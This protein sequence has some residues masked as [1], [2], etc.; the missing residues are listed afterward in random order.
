M[1]K[2]ILILF[3]GFYIFF[4]SNVTAQVPFNADSVN[5]YERGKIRIK[6]KR[7]NLQELSTISLKSSIVNTGIQRLDDL[8]KK[9]G[10]KRMVRVFPFSIKF[11][12]KHRKYGLH[13]WYELD[14]DENLDPRDMADEYSL[15]DEVAIA[16]PLYKKIFLDGTSDSTIVVTIDT[17]RTKGSKVTFKSLKSAVGANLE[18]VEFNDP[19]LPGQ[20]HYHN[21]GTVGK[22]GVDIDLFKA[23][24]KETGDSS[25]IVSVVDGGIDLD[26][27]DIKD[28]LWTN[29]AELNGEEGVDDDG[30]G[31]VDDIHGYNFVYNGAITDHR[32][33]T[34]VAGTVG[35]V[36][37]NGVGVCGVAG[38]DGSGNAVRL[39]SCQVYD[40][41]GGSGNF[42][43]AIVYGADM[44]AVVSQNSWGYTQPGFYE[45]EVYD[46]CKYFIA[47]A[48][49]YE[50]SPMKGGIMFFAAGN[51]GKEETHYPGS[52]P[53]VV[54]VASTGPEGYP[55]PYSTHGDWVDISAPG[56]DQ[57]Y[58]QE[59]GGVLSTLP[60][61]QYGYMQGT[62]MAC[63]HVSGVAALAIAK[64][65]G[66]DLR[67]DN[68]KKIILNSTT[69][70]IFDSQGKYGSGNINAVLA[71]E[72][73][74]FISPDPITD[75][76]ATEVFHNEARL[77]W[78]VPKDSD[79]F[80]PSV[81]IVAVSDEPITAGNFNDRKLYY[82]YNYFDA[83][84]KLS[85]KVGGLLKKSNYWFAVK[86]ADRHGNIS[87]ISNILKVTTTDAPHFQAPDRNFEF[88][89]DVTQNPVQKANLTF[90][91]VGQGNVYWSSFTI[92][93]NPWW[94]PAEEWQETLKSMQADTPPE[95]PLKAESAVIHELKAEQVDQTPEYW[96][97]DKTVFV[98]GYTYVSRPV[99]SAIGSGNTNVGLIHAT[100]FRATKGDFNLTHL[101]L[102]MFNFVKDPVYIEIKRGSEKLEDAKTE[103]VQ[104][105]YP[106]TTM[107]LN[108]ARIPIFKPVHIEKEEYFWVVLYF[109][110]KEPYPLLIHK[111]AWFPRTFYVSKDNG[112]T[113][114]EQWKYYGNVIPY[115][116]AFSTGNDMSYT[117]IS[118][119]EGELHEAQT[120]NVELT[121]DAQRI[122]NGHHLASVGVYTSDVDV[123]GVAIEVKVTVKGQVAKAEVD[124]VYGYDV[125]VSKD[126]KLDIKVKNVGLD[127]LRIYDVIDKESG[128]SVKDFQ[129]SILVN[130][131][132]TQLIPFIFNPDAAGLINRDY[133]L[134]T[135]IGNVNIATEMRS[136]VAPVIMLK[137]DKDNVSVPVDQSS[138]VNLTIAN[139]G[140][141]GTILKYDISKYK[142]AP[143]KNG[144]L[145]EKLDYT[146]KTSHDAVDPVPFNWIDISAYGDD[147]E[148]KYY[149]KRYNLEN[150]FPLYSLM[151]NSM[152]VYNNGLMFNIGYGKL[153]F[154]EDVD[155]G[156]RA[157]GAILPL[158]FERMYLKMSDYY[159]YSF[160]DK[161][162]FSYKM[163]IKQYNETNHLVD[164]GHVTYQ[165]VLYRN[166]TVEY[167]YLDMEA[168]DKLNN[169]VYCVGI[170]G[171]SLGDSKFYRTF[172]DT[173]NNKVYS[174]LTIRFEPDKDVP[175][176]LN[177]GVSSGTIRAK[178]S[179]VVPVTIDPQLYR[180]NI[181]AGNYINY[182]TV[183]SNSD[184]KADTIPLY[185]EVT[186]MTSLI[187]E[188]TVDF[189]E[190]HV[191]FEKVNYLK[192]E[193]TGAKPVTVTSVSF[194]N[195]DFSLPSALPVVNGYAIVQIPI[196]Y[197]P[198]AEGDDNTEA[199]VVFDNGYSKI[200]KILAK[201]LPD[202]GYTINI[203]Q[204]IEK[205][206]HGGE[207]V[208][209]PFTVTNIK[210]GVDLNYKFKNSVFTTVETE[211]IHS[212]EGTKPD[213]L[214]EYGYRWMFSDTTR[215][216]Y[217]WKDLKLDENSVP[218][219]IKPDNQLPVKLPFSFPFYG[220]MYD[221][222]WV[223]VNGYVTVVKPE[224]DKFELEFIKGDG[225]KGMIAPFYSQ[226]IPD[227][228]NSRVWILEESD[229]VYILWDGYRGG[230]VGGS[231]GG[232]YFQLEMVNDGSIYFHYLD[233]KK[234][235]YM[236]NYGLESPDES[237]ILE[238]E[239]SWI[240]SWCRIDDSTTVAISPPLLDKLTTTQPKDFD[241]KLSA[242]CIYVPGTYRDTVI[243]ETNSK[244]QPEYEIPVT[245]N[246]TGTPV[247]V[248]ADSISWDQIIFAGDNTSMRH[249][250]ILTNTGHDVAEVGKITD[251]GLNDFI[252]Y[253]K[254]GDEIK[255]TSTGTLF[256]PIKI[257]PWEKIHL[258][259]EVLIDVNADVDGEVIFGG[260]FE[261][262]TMKVVAKVVDSPVF[263]W[264]AT[265]QS[266]EL[267]NTDKPVY[268]F[269]LENN[270]ETTLEYQLIPAVIPVGEGGEP[271][272]SIVDEL[273]NYDFNQ[274][275]TVDSLAV[276]TKEKAD[277]FEE[278]MISPISLA[279]ANE[280][281][282]PAGGF[283]LT[284]VKVCG[285]FK[286]VGEYI[287]IQV[288]K[289]GDKPQAGK[290]V[291]Q[292]DY[293]ID[294]Y[295]SETWI[296]F[297]LKN[298]VSFE[299]GEHFYLVI[300]PPTADKYI[301]Y[302]IAPNED[303]V[304][305]SWAANWQ[306]WKD[307]WNWQQY[308]NLLRQYKIR[309]LT[310][311][312][313]GL[314]LELD[315]LKG[316]LKGGESVEID[317]VVDPVMAGNG[318][319]KAIVKASTNDVNH[320]RDDFSILLDVNGPPE[321][322]F[323]PNQYNDTVKVKETEKL[324]LNYLF[325]DPEGE[326]MTIT[327]DENAYD[328]K[329]ELVKT[330]ANSAQITFKPDY[331]DA[332]VYHYTVSISDTDGNIVKDQIL[333][334]VLNNNRP[335]EL[336]PEYSQIM[337]NIADPNGTLT[338]KSD[339]LFYDPD[340][341]TLQIYAGNYTPD[342]VD[343]AMGYSYMDLHPLQEG[344]GFV[345]FAADDRKEN[346]FVVY[347]VYVF[348]YDD[349][350]LVSAQ[351]DSFDEE[352]AQRLVG[353]G[354]KFALYPNPVTGPTVNTVYKLDEDAE[355]VVIDIFSID[356]SKIKTIYKG[357][358]EEGIYT[359]NINVGDLQSGLYFCKLIAGGKVVDTIKFF[360][361]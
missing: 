60:D 10:I 198:S 252:I 75:L 64:F 265:D 323:R 212:G 227:N 175:V 266:Y 25:V 271:V 268:T 65:G 267:N 140:E 321:I 73:N 88:V 253:D 351:P 355:E 67:A 164:V 359:D 3:F 149:F 276:E 82:M 260:N 1:K 99:G 39:M 258:E 286:K 296:Y 195:S 289:G 55:A 84:T 104:K 59:K 308:K 326:D 77:Q 127:T 201:A 53:E 335:P 333:L 6:L 41:R 144:L 150:G 353:D 23:W 105:Y 293:V 122:S 309:A 17:T 285:D 66:A 337:L 360:V 151:I 128:N 269:T 219:D 298:P 264:N 173:T 229:R 174:G 12:P 343:M 48:G 346:G 28:N 261:N 26:H 357:S 277:A 310:A 206:V 123:P 119:T 14:F 349:E 147:S 341:D 35:A 249:K 98:D 196:R 211:G 181:Q 45:P 132:G 9:F 113:F 183:S 107:V 165:V 58:Y 155:D 320:P 145:S 179:V 143:I 230:Y 259:V 221:S 350:S 43:A 199:T 187:V 46:A 205:D 93:E 290:L 83:G 131:N 169:P 92:N 80:Q 115:L 358:Q 185:I 141:D 254:N 27:E 184:N 281:I 22:E 314:W 228:E 292:Q 79:D 207:S 218:Y 345:V 288:Y 222:V 70:F 272:D 208:K 278:P 138:S 76:V 194:S 226:L 250:F 50:G 342:I 178:D 328:M 213:T 106:D 37:N 273:G 313:E 42:A 255:R 63:P 270:G 176:I 233:I 4:N 157:R 118:P 217:K 336:N 291:Y 204:N 191:G 120:Q 287:R 251:N 348:V 108:Y 125:Y 133:Y 280:M 30:N 177:E 210:S 101:I 303:A 241:L 49:N 121:V 94:I 246:V 239:H 71:L 171:Y 307:A 245:L 344:V 302:D 318:S 116:F 74:E 137:L 316:E 203:E 13:L 32:H 110:K 7:E 192:I 274:P 295:V 163:S 263:S 275:T 47:E 248:A 57:A 209:V 225:R 299:A 114:N 136:T 5:V 214:Q 352:V 244:A 95:S 139:K 153:D 200:V 324:T 130:V 90:S 279:F 282:A 24:S 236:L 338:I 242:E 325:E 356:G 156:N 235:T 31:Y 312:G 72:K 103:Y 215:A 89:I 247:L 78:T 237:E 19:L 38:G 134:V 193:N 224:K 232:T 21:D 124:D 361:K 85:V 126:N 154:E 161:D 331:S 306:S 142:A 170:Q 330:G 100:R 322:K 56:G 167:N 61:N 152:L 44:G 223:S 334:K 347:G 339:D 158:I 301:G 109:S 51:T 202:P 304:K 190:E 294:L 87:D 112:I 81:F 315:P 311:A 160:G 68:L 2:Y 231:G 69:P 117:F 297:P 354:G 18:D 52:F 234:F 148:W 327:L 283:F 168:L 172:N 238:D 11:E 186:G 129:D 40:D 54:S 96:K 86:S 91:N 97:N 220:G 340:G 102:G 182:I 15:L 111:G 135:N 262:D 16:K 62:S 284:H 319:H 317:A 20:W 29:Y 188:D 329:V 34:H 33:G 162:V 243:L 216:F 257:E 189:G 300:I 146:L 180:H 36:N 332:G 159:Y 240:L 256:E 166:G 197:A 8:N 305:Y